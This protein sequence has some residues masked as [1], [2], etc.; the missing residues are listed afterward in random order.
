MDEIISS[1]Y[2]SANFPGLDTLSKIVQKQ[3]PNITKSYI[4]KWYLNQ[5]EIQLLHNQQ[6]TKASGHI[7]AFSENE[8]WN[9]DIFDLSKH[10]DENGNMKYIFACVDVF[11][12][13]LYAEPMTSKDG[14]NCAGVLQSIIMEHKVKPRTILCDSDAAYSSK[15]FKQV[16]EE[17]EIKLN[18]VVVGDHNAMGIRHNMAM[19][20]KLIFNKLFIGNK[21]KKWVYKLQQV[22]TSYKNTEHSSIGGLKPNQAQDKQYFDMLFKKF[23]DKFD[24]FKID[25]LIINCTLYN[26]LNT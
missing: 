6:R 1:I 15:A 3:H 10:W 4:K 18:Q 9:I 14:D 16:L 26:F 21:N 12:R 11:T 2:E 7:V 24:Q 19:R 8:M 22:V 13:K 23:I 17:N 5:L 25:T 20:L